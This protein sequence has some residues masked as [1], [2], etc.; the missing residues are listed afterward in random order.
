MAS[1]TVVFPHLDEPRRLRRGVLW[2]AWCALVGHDVDNRVFARTG[3][4]ARTCPCGEPIL[5]EDGSETH[6]AHTL[7]CFFLGHVYSTA[8]DRDGHRESVCE[9]CGHPLV[10]RQGS[11]YAA[12]ARFRKPVRYL[13]GIFGHRVHEVTTRDGHVE[14]ACECG[15]SFLGAE[16]AGSLVRHRMRCVLSGH[17]VR[18]VGRRAGYSE[19]RCRDCGHPFCHPWGR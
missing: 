15:H 17:R 5:R 18:F 19:F 7:S 11:R 1:D 6:V 10:V 13:C 2:R 12:R 3:G 14:H 16:P 4:A 8:C 9:R